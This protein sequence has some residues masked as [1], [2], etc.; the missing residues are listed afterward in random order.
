MNV[1]IDASEHDDLHDGL[2][3]IA[4]SKSIPRLVCDLL[5]GGDGS[6]P[7]ALHIKNVEKLYVITN[8]KKADDTTPTNN[9]PQPLPAAAAT[10]DAATPK[11]KKKK[12]RRKRFNRDK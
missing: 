2:S 9:T 5:G 6:E 3:G 7:A 11:E 1:K 12:F 10:D 8:N 4:S